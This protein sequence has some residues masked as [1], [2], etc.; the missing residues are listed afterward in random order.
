[1]LIHL[2]LLICVAVS[3]ANPIYGRRSEYEPSKVLYDQKQEGGWNI[4][5]DL[6]NFLFVIIP[7]VKSTPAANS[8]AL[9]SSPL[10]QGLLYLLS[11]SAN[12]HKHHQHQPTHGK[13][14]EEPTEE[15]KHFIESKSA[16]YQVDIS[17]TSGG[18]LSKLY[19]EKTEDEG[20]LVARSPT[21]SLLKDPASGRMAKALILSVPSEDIV[22]TKSKRL[23]KKAM[24]DQLKKSDVNV[25]N[26]QPGQVRDSYGNC[27]VFKY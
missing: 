16:P 9:S 3:N 8:S 13:P 23:K 25:S 24:E 17:K 18:L 12:A 4:H 11:K 1:M 10:E 15:T 26:C 19:P 5:A 20:V 6:K 21:I 22:I 7:A 14:E 2:G 27:K